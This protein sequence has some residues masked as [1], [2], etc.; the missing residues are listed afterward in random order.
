MEEEF[1][2]LVNSQTKK[3]YMQIKALF[4]LPAYRITPETAE[5]LLNILNPI[6]SEPIESDEEFL[7]ISARP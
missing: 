2:K 7:L 3:T 5:L 4:G 6:V 1:T